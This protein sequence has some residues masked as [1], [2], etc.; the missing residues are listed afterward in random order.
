MIPCQQACGFFTQC[1]NDFGQR[2]RGHAL[3]SSYADADYFASRLT[4]SPVKQWSHMY[5]AIF[6]TLEIGSRSRHGTLAQPHRSGNARRISG[7]SQMNKPRCR[8]KCSQVAT[9]IYD[10]GGNTVV[11]QGFDSTINRKTFGDPAKVDNQRAAEKDLVVTA[12]KDVTRGR[13]WTELITAIRKVI[14]LRKQS[15][16][17]NIKRALAL[18]GKPLCDFHDLPGPRVHD[19]TFYKS[20][21][22]HP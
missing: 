17:G 12:K 16:D 20:V 14:P 13:G 3:C 19:Y 11:F 4:G 6:S 15:S 9:G 18:F 22:I 7:M 2:I 1:K 8:P 5:A 21:A 10:S